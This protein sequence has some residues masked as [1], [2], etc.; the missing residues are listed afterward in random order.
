MLVKTE[1]I[2]LNTIKHTDSGI[3][4]HILTKEYGKLSFMVKGVHSKKGGTKAVYF[5]ALQIL[6]IEL[7]YKEGRNL[8]SIKE[9]SIAYKLN[10]IPVNIYRGSIA[11][12][13][14]EI[15]YR[16]LNET[17]A[18]NS[19]YNYIRESIIYLDSSEEEVPNFH[20]GFLVGLSRY[21][22]ILPSYGENSNGT[23]FDIQNGN[24]CNTPPLHGYYLEKEHTLL[25]KQFLGSTIN[26]CE[27][28]KLTGKTRGAFLQS[29]L[30]FF[31]FHLPGIK[32][33]K[34]LEVLSQ[35]FS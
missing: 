12:F 32:K 5:Q 33:V 17:E 14:S 22:G 18:N 31:S 29:I 34:S 21:L 11:M 23:F 25:L 10:T 30:N 20:L 35:L 26:D 8:N 27:K 1:G 6:D 13:A 28:I 16:T 19:L 15:V 7:Y 3:I 9:V 4:A 24:F 2:V